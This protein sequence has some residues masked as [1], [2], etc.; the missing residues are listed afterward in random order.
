MEIYISIMDTHSWY[1]DVHKWIVVQ[2]MYQ[3]TWKSGK[4]YKVWEVFPWKLLKWWYHFTR[5]LKTPKLHINNRLFSPELVAMAC[6][7]SQQ[8][9]ARNRPLKFTPTRRK[10]EVQLKLIPWPQLTQKLS[11]NAYIYIYQ[12]VITYVLHMSIKY[13]SEK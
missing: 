12:S 7:S 4:W 2:Y 11:T 1:M 10:T 5:N 8:H 3:N 6:F 9:P 13:S